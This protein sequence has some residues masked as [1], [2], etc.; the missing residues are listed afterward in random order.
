MTDY[1]SI[2]PEVREKAKLCTTTEELV[3]LAKEEGVE[4]TD[5]MLDQVSG[6]RINWVDPY[7]GTTCKQND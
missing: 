5:E 7:D 2:P 6:G 3:A 1:D 4:L